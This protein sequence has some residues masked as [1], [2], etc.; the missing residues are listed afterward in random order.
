MG[1]EL[2]AHR[3]MRAQSDQ[4]ADHF[5]AK[6]SA[7]LVVEPHVGKPRNLALAH[8]NAADDLRQIFAESDLQDQPLDI[9][10]AVL[11]RQPARPTRHLPQRLDISRQPSQRMG[12]TLFAVEY[13][14]RQ[15]TIRHQTP[16][17]PVFRG[18][19]QAFAG[20]HGLV[21]ARQKVRGKHCPHDP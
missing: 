12:R 20:Q 15:H 4:L 5:A 7:V 19:E 16:A 18:G 17:D 9:T 10:Q 21:A 13:I 6:S 3:R 1:G 14:A 8:G 2:R 11:V